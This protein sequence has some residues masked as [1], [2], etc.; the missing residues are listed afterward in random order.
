VENRDLKQ[1]LEEMIEYSQGLEDRLGNEANR[2]D[3]PN[4]QKQFII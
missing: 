1:E 4:D 2:F 3:K